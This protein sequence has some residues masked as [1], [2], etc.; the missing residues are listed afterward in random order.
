MRIRKSLLLTSAVLVLGAATVLAAQPPARKTGQS[1]GNA[2]AAKAVSPEDVKRFHVT[3][4]DGDIAPNTL[5]VK[6]GERV[7]I[8]FVSKDGNYGIKFKDFDISNKVAPGKPAVV[9]LVAKQKGTYEFR[10]SKTW[11]I[12]HNNGTLVVE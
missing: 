10:C 8:T 1:K 9:E 2:V 5:H 6:R 7:R 4:N 12:H 11:G 3:A